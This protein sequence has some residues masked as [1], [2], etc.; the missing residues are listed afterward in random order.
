MPP[1]KYD[2]IRYWI[3]SAKLLI[4]HSWRSLCGSALCYV[5][6]RSPILMSLPCSFEYAKTWRSFNFCAL[7][8]ENCS[9]K[10]VFKIDIWLALKL[11]QCP[12]NTT[13]L[14]SENSNGSAASERG[15]VVPVDFNWISRFMMP[16]IA[17]LGL[18][19]DW[20]WT[21]LFEI[22]YQYSRLELSSN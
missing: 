3:F 10:L 5:P 15:R 9:S 11:K 4:W 17:V 19:G 22:W 18:S 7:R 1:V 20:E 8:Y 13:F 12:Q 14:M 21:C 16:R 6:T 2:G